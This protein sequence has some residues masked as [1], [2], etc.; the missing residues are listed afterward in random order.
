MVL[1]NCKEDLMI[2][3]LTVI[4]KKIKIRIINPG[5]SSK[6]KKSNIKIVQIDKLC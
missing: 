3:E 2:K 4:V 1:V 5:I 6:N